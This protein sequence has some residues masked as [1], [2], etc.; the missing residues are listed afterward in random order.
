MIGRGGATGLTHGPIASWTLVNP[1][2]F[3]KTAQT[4][5]LWRIVWTWKKNHTSRLDSFNRLFQNNICI[6]YMYYDKFMQL[7]EHKVGNCQDIAFK[8]VHINRM[9]FLC[10]LTGNICYTVKGQLN[11]EWIY[12]VIVSSKIPTKNYR[13]FCPTL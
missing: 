2:D 1:T 6:L 7:F 4:K 12:E 10:F 13:D 8:K 3:A 9:C 11:S 5:W